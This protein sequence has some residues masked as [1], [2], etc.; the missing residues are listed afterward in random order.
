MDDVLIFL[1]IQLCVVIFWRFSYLKDSSSKTA[2]QKDSLSIFQI[3]TSSQNHRLS[4]N[5]TTVSSSFN[6]TPVFIFYALSALK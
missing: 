4:Q 1:G 3:E 5:L 2:A 6:I